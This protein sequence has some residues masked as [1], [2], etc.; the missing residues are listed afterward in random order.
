MA[1]GGG[2]GG[3]GGSGVF[4]LVGTTVHC[5]AENKGPYCTFSKL[6]NVLLWIIILFFLGKFALEYLKKKK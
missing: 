3:V 6:M 4:G 1:R 5:D 2:N